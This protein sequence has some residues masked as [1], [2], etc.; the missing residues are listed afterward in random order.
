MTQN[1][2][3]Y[4]RIQMHKE[5]IYDKINFDIWDLNNIFKQLL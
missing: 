3:L 4:T 5:L 2:H 1:L